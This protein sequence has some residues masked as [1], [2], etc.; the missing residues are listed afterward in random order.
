MGDG[1]TLD[2]SSAG[3]FIVAEV[4]PPAGSC[5]ELEISLPSTMGSPS[6]AQLLGQGR[7]VRIAKKNS[8]KG[9][10]AEVI[11]QAERA[12]GVTGLSPHRKQ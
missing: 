11:F 10:A 8:Q 9:F 3:V 5:L 12:G 7:V 2:I 4:V 1:W 6:S